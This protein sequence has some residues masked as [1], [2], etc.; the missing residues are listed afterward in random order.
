[1]KAWVTGP[2]AAD[3]EGATRLLRIAGYEVSSPADVP[4]E[5]ADDLRRVLQWS[6]DG[7]LNADV[8]VMLPGW[9]TGSATDVEVFTAQ[10]I[11]TP[12][13][14]LDEALATEPERLVA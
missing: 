10:A 14:L 4:A 2:A 5:L 9:E 6:T 11:G 1:M 12:V 7:V 13:L 8:V 3:F